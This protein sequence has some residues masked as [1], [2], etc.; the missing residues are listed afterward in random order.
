MTKGYGIE[1]IKKKKRSWCLSACAYFLN[2]LR[3]DEKI[4]KNIYILNREW[5]RSE[6]WYDVKK[7]VFNLCLIDG[8]WYKKKALIQFL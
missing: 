3:L 8:I 6:Y 4:N 7:I 2:T 5:F 1:V